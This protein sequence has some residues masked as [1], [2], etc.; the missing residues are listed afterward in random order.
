MPYFKNKDM[1]LL[2]IHIPKTGGS[3]LEVYF[4]RKYDVSLNNKSL[5]DFMLEFS[6]I[7]LQH[8]TYNTILKNNNIFNINFDC[9]TVL[10][11]VRNPYNRI[12]SDLMYYSLIDIDTTPEKVFCI[13]SENYISKN[14]YDNHNIPQYCFIVDENNQIYK[15][16]KILKTE[17]L[18]NDMNNLGFTDFDVRVHTN[19]SGLSESQYIKK[20]LNKDSIDLI[21]N[22]YHYDFIFFNYS[23]I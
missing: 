20:F 21:N 19:K 4:S 11:I 15:N 7:S 8:Q 13:I 9:A 12:I 18:T 3:S 17:T 23:K 2:F 16:I 22:Y 6:N 10:T 14:I 5:F 1:D